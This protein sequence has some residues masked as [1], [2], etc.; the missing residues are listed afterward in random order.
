MKGFSNSLNTHYALGTKTLATCWKVTLTNGTVKGFTEHDSD[1]TVSSVTYLAAPGYT[2]SDIQISAALNVDNM[3]IIGILNS[4]FITEQELNSGLW[5]FAHVM[6]FRVNYNDLS[7]GIDILC[8]GHLGEVT[9]GRISFTAELRG[10]TQA[11]SRTIG[12]LYSPGCRA[13]LGDA[14]CGVN[15]ATYTFTDEVDTVSADNMSI[16]S[17]LTN[18]PGYF[19][20]GKITFT[21]GLNNGLSMEVKTYG[22]GTFNL[23][24]PMPNLIVAGD[25]FSV[26]AG[27]NKMLKVNAYAY[28]HVD[29]SSGTTIND[30]SRTE[31][32]GYFT[33]G[34]LTWMSGLNTNTSQ[35]VSSSSVGSLVLATA[36]PNAISNSDLYIVNPA[37]SSLYSGDC[38]VKFNNV[39]NFRGEAD[40]PGLD[41][42]LQV[43]GRK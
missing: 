10:L 33:G 13:D 20:F 3:E 17:G 29:T 5:D 32:S 37:N 42:V 40:L 2:P 6:Q 35:N 9:A 23:Q 24:L 19:N 8:T 41:K 4:P 7:A 21:S 30:A 26:Y 38:K 27:C 34:V 14:R 36:P 18:P 15:L 11:Y 22:A 43:G 28:G 1:L 16:T 25:T 31:A 39:V 12:Q